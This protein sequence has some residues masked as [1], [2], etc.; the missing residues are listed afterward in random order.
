MENK[1]CF[2]LLIIISLFFSCNSH[3]GYDIEYKGNIIY[4]TMNRPTI[5]LSGINEINYGDFSPDD[6]GESICNK[7]K[8]DSGTYSIYVTF[9]SCDDSG[10]Y[11]TEE[12]CTHLMDVDAATVSSSEIGSSIHHLATDIK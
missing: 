7:I 8:G 9:R 2:Y 6:I 4:V 5:G 1:K 11:V 10:Q 3:S 12:N